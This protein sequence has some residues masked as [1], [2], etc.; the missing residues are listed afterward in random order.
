[1]KILLKAKHWHLFLLTFGL[2]VLFQSILMVT[3]FINIGSDPSWVFGYLKFL[4]V[5]VI[6][7]SGVLYGW[8]WAVAVG[9]QNK[10]PPSV[11]MEVNKFK[12]LYFIPITYFIIIVGAVAFL[13]SA[14][15][16]QREQFD[17]D[18]SVLF[19]GMAIVLPLHFAAVACIFY[20]FY[21]IA[22]TIKTV[23]LQRE[24]RFSEFTGEFFLIWFYPIGVWL[25][26]PRINKIIEADNRLQ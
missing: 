13:V 11:S 18:A 1:M 10:V 17:L 5:Y 9:L 12:W 23:E 15:V 7:V 26:Q 25:I 24:V 2:P 6:I 4:P 3:T 20:C 22:K 8:Y 21:F 19:I 16:E 14:A